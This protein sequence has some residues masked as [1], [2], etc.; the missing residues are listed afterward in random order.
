MPSCHHDVDVAR[1]LEA[2]VN[3][4]MVVAKDNSK[5]HDLLWESYGE[6][7]NGTQPGWKNQKID[8]KELQKNTMKK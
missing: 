8:N 5:A 2:G 1:L 7:R 3:T 4:V 6:G